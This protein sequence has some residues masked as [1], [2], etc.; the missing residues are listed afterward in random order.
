MSFWDVNL[1]C[2]L[3]GL[4]GGLG[5]NIRDP[6]GSGQRSKTGTFMKEKRVVRQELPKWNALVYSQYD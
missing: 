6:E 2:I 3:K 5:R 4:E 1:K